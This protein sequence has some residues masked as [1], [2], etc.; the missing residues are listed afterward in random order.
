[1]VLNGKQ[2]TMRNQNSKQKKISMLIRL[3][4]EDPVIKK[5]LIE[6]LQ[7]SSFERRFELN[8]WLEKLRQRK[9]SEN[10]C[11]MLL[12]LFDD[13]VAEQIRKLI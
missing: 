4:N 3:T 9:A 5:R 6:L 1:M 13:R 7:L 11:N 2:K 8:I 12:I 10:L